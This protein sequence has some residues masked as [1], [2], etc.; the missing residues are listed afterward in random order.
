MML[1]LNLY[2]KGLLD[3]AGEVSI[4][5]DEQ[6]AIVGYWSVSDFLSIFDFLLKPSVVMVLIGGFMCVCVYI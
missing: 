5:L 6:Y 1:N 2:K 4:D 3:G